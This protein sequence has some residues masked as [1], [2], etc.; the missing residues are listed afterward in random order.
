MRLF[1]V[2]L[3]LFYCYKDNRDQSE[4]IRF[5]KELYNLYVNN[6]EGFLIFDDNYN[7]KLNYDDLEKYLV[8]KGYKIEIIDYEYQACI[9]EKK[10]G[11]KYCFYLEKK[12]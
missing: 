9:K 4:C 7:L 11:I 3:L 10:E 6:F 8:D 2:L 1:M 12:Q 5:E